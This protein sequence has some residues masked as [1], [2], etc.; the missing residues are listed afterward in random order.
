LVRYKCDH[1]E[2]SGPPAAKWRELNGAREIIEREECGR[3][4]TPAAARKK[5][6]VLEDFG[7][8]DL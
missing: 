8:R 4:K 1:R 6:A 2:S 5:G 7:A 3:G